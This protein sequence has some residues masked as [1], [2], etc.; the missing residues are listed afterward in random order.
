MRYVYLLQSIDDSTKRYIGLAYD[1]ER[2]L[3]EHNSGKSIY[4]NKHKPWR[5]VAC[6]GFEDEQ[7]AFDFERYLKQG[8]GHAFANKHFWHA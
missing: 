8:S 2:R 4:T 1:V 7:K 6:F 3:D 5:L